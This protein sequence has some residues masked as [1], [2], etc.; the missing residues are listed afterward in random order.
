MSVKKKVL[1][2]CDLSHSSP[3]VPGYVQALEAKGFEVWVIS[4]RI[5][6]NKRKFLKENLK[7]SILYCP[8]YSPREKRGLILNL[9]KLLHRLFPFTILGILKANLL[10]TF[11]HQNKRQLENLAKR[12]VNDYKIEIVISTSSPFYCHEVASKIKKDFGVKWFADYRD[13]WSLNHVLSANNGVN[14]IY[15]SSVIESSDGVITVAKFLKAQLTKLYKGPI[16]VL[17]N[18]FYDVVPKEISRLANEIKIG[19]FG[20]IYFGFH[21]VTFFIDNLD[22]LNKT[23]KN[24]KYYSLNFYGESSKQILKFYR[25]RGERLPDFINLKGSIK[26]WDLREVQICNDFL[27]IFNWLEDDFKGALPTKLYDYMST[28][29][30]ILASGFRSEDECSRILQE[31]GLGIQLRSREDFIDWNSIIQSSE[32]FP[33]IQNIKAVQCYSFLNQLEKLLS[34][35][36]CDEK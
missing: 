33:Y 14:N 30:P 11:N 22:L 3:R 29:K 7:S 35:I 36:G 9:V 18:G 19:Y 32:H 20:Q 17:R 27:L 16:Y 15:E 25:S 5:S 34:D 28:G 12:I 23:S 4:P 13:L 26:S 1:V 10:T 8:S 24:E 31:T 21:D 2:I 6:S